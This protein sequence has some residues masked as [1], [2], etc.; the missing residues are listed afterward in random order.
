MLGSTFVGAPCLGEQPGPAAEQKQL[1]PLGL[2]QLPGMILGIGAGDLRRG[3]GRRHPHVSA[4]ALSSHA[5]AHGSALMEHEVMQNRLG[6]AGKDLKH[7][8]SFSASRGWA[9]GATPCFQ[10]PSWNTGLSATSVYP[11]DVECQEE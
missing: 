8:P 7:C 9:K 6:S 4:G 11:A 1:C 5:V 3:M 2:G 10:K